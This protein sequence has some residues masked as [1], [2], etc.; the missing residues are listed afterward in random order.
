[1]SLALSIAV[2]AMAPNTATKVVGTGGVAPYTYEV[3]SGGAGGTISAI[4]GNE[5]LYTAPSSAPLEGDDA[6]DTI[7]VTDDNGDTAEAEILIGTPL[8]LFCEIIQKEMELANGR[9]YLWNQKLMQPKDSDLYIAVSVLNCKP[10]GNTNRPDSSGVGVNSVQS[11]NMQ[12][13]IAIDIISRSLQAQRRKEEVLMALAS[14]Y[15]QQQQERNSFYIGQL[16]PAA[17]FVNLAEV[18]GAAI[19]YRY[20]ISINIQ[21]FA[22]KTKAVD[23]F[24]DFSDVEVETES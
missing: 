15:S 6:Y 18:D 23:Y 8:E 7:R 4:S 3:V 17:Q 19:P 11:V 21:Y 2:T 1:M 10:F 5:G 16:P 22:T 12:A 20:N 14:T 13:T 24:D 9:V